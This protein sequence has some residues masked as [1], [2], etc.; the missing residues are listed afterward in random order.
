MN[1]DSTAGL[2]GQ[3]VACLRGGRLV[4]AR[5]DFGFAPGELVVLRGANGAGKSSLLR[6]LAGLLPPAH[7]R[8][9]WHGA[10]IA[11]DPAGHRARLQYVGHQDA[12]KPALSPA[13]HLTFH[14]ALRGLP[15]SEVAGALS[16][17]GLENLAA[18]PVRFL[19]QGQRRRVALARLCVAPAAIWLLDEPTNGL[20]E[21]SVAQLGAAIAQ[22]RE[23]GGIVVAATHLDFPGTGARTLTLGGTA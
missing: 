14:A 6:V 9:A 1:A 23:G 5:L 19:S 12:L 18:T 16:A 11:E 20:D 17:F 22:K 8:L 15:R 21:R 2:T 3:D 13:E 7:G 10:D 4:F